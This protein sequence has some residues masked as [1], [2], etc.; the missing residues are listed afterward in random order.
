MTDVE[1]EM[2]SE[3]NQSFSLCPILG[4]FITLGISKLLWVTWVFKLTV[5]LQDRVQ[6][7]LEAFN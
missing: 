5:R 6:F 2:L 1:G 3:H 4:A 7:Q